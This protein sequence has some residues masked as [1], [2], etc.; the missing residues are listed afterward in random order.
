MGTLS[1]VF[2]MIPPTDTQQFG[3]TRFFPNHFNLLTRLRSKQV[4]S[5]NRE[6]KEEG[7]GEGDKKEKEKTRRKRIM[8]REEK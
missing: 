2:R 4:L 7:R 6:E 3:I 5:C 1:T 8:R